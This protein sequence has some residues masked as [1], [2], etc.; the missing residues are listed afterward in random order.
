M[1]IVRYW[2]GHQEARILS[3]KINRLSTASLSISWRIRAD[4]TLIRIFLSLTVFRVESKLIL[5]FIRIYLP[6]VCLGGW[7]VGGQ[8]RTKVALNLSWILV[9]GSN[10]I[11]MTQPSS[12]TY[13]LYYGISLIDPDLLGTME[14]D[15]FYFIFPFCLIRTK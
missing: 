12:R 10:Q 5:F 9:L 15:W 6:L 2:M 3:I 8:I 4:F 11:R 1:G 13:W 14:L 7:A